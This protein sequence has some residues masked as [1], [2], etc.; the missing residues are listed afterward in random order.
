MNT[1]EQKVAPVP[2][3]KAGRCWNGS[4]RDSGTV[5]HA[6]EPLSNPNGHW[7]KKALCGAV[8]GT[9]SYGWTNTD[10]E[11]NCSKCLKNLTQK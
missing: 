1:A 4:H 7:F 3:I 5:V 8:P 2:A 9:R 11:I 10:K 6:V